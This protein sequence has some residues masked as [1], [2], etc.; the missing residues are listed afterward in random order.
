[1]ACS[2]YKNGKCIHGFENLNIGCFGDDVPKHMTKFIQPCT[3]E[4]YCE[5][6]YPET[7]SPLTEKAY[8]DGENKK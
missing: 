2:G 1:M 7:G 6:C 5:L 3:S 8:R 4:S